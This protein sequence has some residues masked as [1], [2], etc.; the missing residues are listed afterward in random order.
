MSAIRD[1][2][3]VGGE[4]TRLLIHWLSAIGHWSLRSLSLLTS[5]FSQ[6][7]RNPDSQ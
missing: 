4:V 7:V 6:P 2:E 1:E 3:I 5:N